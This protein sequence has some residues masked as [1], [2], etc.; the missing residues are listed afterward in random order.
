MIEIPQN[1]TLPRNERNFRPLRQYLD[2]N[3][4][5]MSGQTLRLVINKEGIAC[6][7]PVITATSQS[8]GMRIKSMEG[9]IYCRFLGSIIS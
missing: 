1:Q 9:Q 3:Q 5:P 2:K 6:G 4:E 7:T 8:L